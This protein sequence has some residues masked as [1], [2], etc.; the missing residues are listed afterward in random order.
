[1]TGAHKGIKQPVAV[2]RGAGR[3]D[4]DRPRWFQLCGVRQRGPFIDAFVNGLDLEAAGFGRVRA[5]TTG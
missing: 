5:K 4:H 2:C 3:R 1:M